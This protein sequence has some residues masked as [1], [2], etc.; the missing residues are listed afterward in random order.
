MRVLVVALAVI[1]MAGG[2]EHRARLVSPFAFIDSIPR[3]TDVKRLEDLAT[4]TDELSSEVAI[5]DNLGSA[6]HLTR[7]RAYARLGELGTAESLAAVRRIEAAAKQWTN[8]PDTIPR[9]YAEHVHFG[10]QRIDPIAK[11]T[12]GDGV[13]YG[14]V[15]DTLLGPP[16]AFLVSTR[17]P[18]DAH[19]WTRPKL[20]PGAIYWGVSNARLT[21]RGPDRLVFTFTQPMPKGMT[22]KDSGTFGPVVPPFGSYRW[23]I[24]I[25]DIERDSDLDG[26]TDFEEQRLGLDPHN[27]DTDRD[28]LPDGRDPAPAYRATAANASYGPNIALQKAFFAAFGLT[29]ARHLLY[30]RPESPRF[31]PWGYEGPIIF[32][33]DRPSVDGSRMHGE[34]YV[35]WKITKMTD[36]EIQI[37]LSDLLYGTGSGRDVLLRKHGS[38]WF[39]VKHTDTWIA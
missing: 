3:L 1:V 12:G 36:T 20:I 8:T 39:V 7:V 37:S 35:E 16:Q 14:I 30:V 6:G 33:H 27:P 22:M 21:W 19:S 5:Y 23:E 28:G 4:R 29:H 26:W 11:T 31:Q 38:E 17:S 25:A 18:A 13:E 2:A 34:V 10:A 15:L 24:S 32:E 9:A